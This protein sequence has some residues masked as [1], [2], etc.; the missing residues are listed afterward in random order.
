[1]SGHH[2]SLSPM[3][4]REW[5]TLDVRSETC[6]R[7]SYMHRCKALSL[8]LIRSSSVH[9]RPPRR[10]LYSTSISIV[11]ETSNIIFVMS[12]TNEVDVC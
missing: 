5:P 1:M 4:T 9:K 3:A 7:Q 2:P 6:L 8:P 10:W 12:P 11:V